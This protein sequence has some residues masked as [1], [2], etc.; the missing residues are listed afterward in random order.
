MFFSYSSAAQTWIQASN[1]PGTARDDGSQFTIGNKTY[2][3]LGLDLNFSCTNDFYSFDMFTETWLAFAN[4]PIGNNRQYACGFTLKQQGYIFGG[5]TCVNFFQNDLWEYDPTLNSW[6]CKA[7]LP[8]VGRSG[9]AV[10]TMNNAAYIIGGR[11]S[12]NNGIA[13]VWAYDAGNDS[14]AQKAS[15]PN[16][17]M[18]RG[19]AYQYNG[20]GYAGLGKNSLDQYNKQFYQYSVATNQWGA[21]QGFTY[22]PRAYAGYSQ[23]N[24]FGFLFG[25]IDSLGIISSTLDK[26]N[27]LNLTVNTLPNFPDTARKGCI[28]FVGPN[29]YYITTGASNNKRFKN[30]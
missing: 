28:T 29:G 25:G 23:I 13:E 4:L 19:V 15:L 10:F 17:G 24:E 26:I 8:S 1:F 22:S 5:V 30:T 11:T 20:L 21:T 14:W 18:W 12:S 2:C 3:G 9:S 16:N 27:L 7:S 6:A